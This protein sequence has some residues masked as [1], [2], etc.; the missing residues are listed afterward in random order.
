MVNDLHYILMQDY[1]ILV[2]GCLLNHKA[3]YIYKKI[4]KMI[5][6]IKGG[7]ILHTTTTLNSNDFSYLMN[8]SLVTLEDIFPNF[9]EN[10]RIGIV[11]SEKGGSIGASALL[12]AAITRFYDFYRPHLG[13]K[14]NETW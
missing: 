3:S 7:F 5:I 13:N 6:L 12:M 1:F 14:A 11:V 2:K 4:R 9:N 10:D 8:N